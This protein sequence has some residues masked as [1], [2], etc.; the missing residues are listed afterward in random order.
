MVWIDD[1]WGMNTQQAIEAFKKMAECAHA[2]GYS[3]SAFGHYSHA[4]GESNLCKPEPLHVAEALEKYSSSHEVPTT[5]EVDM[6]EKIQK[7]IE[8]W[9][10]DPGINCQANW[11]DMD[12]KTWQIRRIGEW[13]SCGGPGPDQN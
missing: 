6:L 3:T 11:E 2:Y 9:L 10:K 13:V 1:R 4:E 7:E 8:D 12:N 5:E